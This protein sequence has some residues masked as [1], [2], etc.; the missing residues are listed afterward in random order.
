MA[1]LGAIGAC[2][3]QPITLFGGR[4][5]GI[6]KDDSA[7][8]CRRVVRAYDRTTGIQSGGAISDATT[9]LYSIDTSIY[10]PLAEH[11]VVE[12]DD[13]INQ[14]YNARVFDRVIPI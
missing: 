13:D 7:T 9:G 4:I 8:P 11:F 10:F 5:S 12:L 3:A 1:D 14:Q 2:R 6:V